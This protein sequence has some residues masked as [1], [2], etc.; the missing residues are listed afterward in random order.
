M[1]LSCSTRDD[2]P[3]TQSLIQQ[4]IELGPDPIAI[5]PLATNA[6]IAGSFARM[7]VLH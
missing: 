2:V 7:A 1:I 4:R 5:T 3:L 6:V